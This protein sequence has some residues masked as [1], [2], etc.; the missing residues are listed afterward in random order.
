M[1]VNDAVH[2]V[3]TNQAKVSINGCSGAALKV[4]GAVFVMR[5]AGIGVLKIRDGNCSLY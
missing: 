5:Q 4:P 2:E 3:C 1:G